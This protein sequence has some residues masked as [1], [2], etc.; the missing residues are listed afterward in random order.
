MN[1]AGTR[2]ETVYLKRRREDAEENAEK[3]KLKGKLDGR[4][5][6]RLFPG[7]ARGASGD[8]GGKIQLIPARIRLGRY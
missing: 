5:G 8:R 3:S 6:I 2:Q 1:A 4:S 7:V